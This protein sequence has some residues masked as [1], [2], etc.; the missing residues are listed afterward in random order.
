MSSPE[1]AEQ[2]ARAAFVDVGRV[3][4]GVLIAI[5]GFAVLA[6][7]VGFVAQM[8]YAIVA[9]LFFFVPQRILERRDEDPEEWGMT[10]GNIWRGIGWGLGATLLTLPFFIPGYWIWETYFLKRSFEPD[11]ARYRQWSVELDG[12]PD[13]WGQDEAGVWIWSHRDE[14]HVGL[15]NDGGPNNRVRIEADVPFKPTRRGTVNITPEQEGAA[16]ARVWFVA[17]THSKSRGVVRIRGPDDI[18]VRVEP[19]ADGNPTWPL[20]TGPNADPAESNEYSDE[21]G[22]MW[23]FLWVATQFVLVAFPEEYFYRGFIQTRLEQGFEARAEA[24]GKAMAVILGFTPAILVSS[25]LFGIGHLLVPVGGA[26][27]GNRMSVFFPALLF[28]WLR[29]RTGSILA[30]TIYHAFSN[31]MVLVAAVHF[32]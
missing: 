28:G 15:R 21:R 27:L 16:K 9:F 6:Q 2:R 18:R 3:F 22:W 14:I 23:L 26:I 7:F 24:K 8:L 30:S 13:S 25:I 10:A 11:A 19:V 32:V 31:M 1:N 29:R 12:E 17:P 20:Y 5:I 4:G